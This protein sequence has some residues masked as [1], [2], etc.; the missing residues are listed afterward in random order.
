MASHT[1]FS[2][3][4]SLYSRHTEFEGSLTLFSYVGVVLFTVWTFD[5]DIRPV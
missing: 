1:E 3:V 4:V 2:N 5:M